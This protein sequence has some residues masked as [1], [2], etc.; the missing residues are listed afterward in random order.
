MSSEM[1]ETP[2]RWRRIV[3]NKMAAVRR[4]EIRVVQ[5]E[6]QLKKKKFNL[7]QLNLIELIWKTSQF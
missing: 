2:R 6:N 1:N 5:V 4:T 7:N 3:R